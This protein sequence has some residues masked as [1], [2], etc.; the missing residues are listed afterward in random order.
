MVI[1]AI[2]PFVLYVEAL[3]RSERLKAATDDEIELLYSRSKLNI[4]I[5]PIANSRLQVTYINDQS[6]NNDGA[7]TTEITMIDGYNTSSR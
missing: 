3:S 4:L 5:N 7:G 2:T 1:V 6:F